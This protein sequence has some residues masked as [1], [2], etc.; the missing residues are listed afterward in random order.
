MFNCIEGFFNLVVQWEELVW[1]CTKY[2]CLDYFNS[3][4]VI[5]FNGSDIILCINWNQ[6]RLEIR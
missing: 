4:D 5:N 1:N 2:N 3:C 6:I